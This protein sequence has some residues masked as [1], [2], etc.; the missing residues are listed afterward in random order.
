MLAFAIDTLDT[1][2]QKILYL[3]CED[4]LEVVTRNN[5]EHDKPIEMHP[6]EELLETVAA[7]ETTPIPPMGYTSSFISLSNDN[8]KLLPSILHAPKL[9]L[10]TLPDHLKYVFLGENETLPVIIFSNL[11]SLQEEK[12]IRV[13]KDHRTSI[14]W[15]IADIKGISP[16][17][18]I[19]K[20]ILEDGAKPTR[21]AQMRLNPSND[22][23]CKEIDF[24]AFKSWSHLS[25]FR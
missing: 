21:E 14:G 4:T 19:H 8:E 23:L 16:S 12:L 5:L 2:A 7:L 10:K 15:T 9:E 3:D 18:C 1:L 20:I 25:N 17:T 6:S 13:L 24:K 22:G 11:S